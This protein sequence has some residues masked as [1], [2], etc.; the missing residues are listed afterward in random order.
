MYF[1]EKVF[2]T[3]CCD[4]FFVVSHSF[5]LLFLYLWNNTLEMW[6]SYNLC[7]VS[8]MIF[9]SYKYTGFIRKSRALRYSVEL[10]SLFRSSSVT[11]LSALRIY[12]NILLDYLMN[13]VF[14]NLTCLWTVNIVGFWRFHASTSGRDIQLKDNAHARFLVSVNSPFHES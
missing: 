12:N 9:P 7:F 14:E 5:D 6:I 3:A 8:D 11:W 1:V 2:Q 13:N 10:I 4:Q